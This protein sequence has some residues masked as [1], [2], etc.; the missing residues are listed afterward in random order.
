M[1]VLLFFAREVLAISRRHDVS[2]HQYI[3]LADSYPSVGK[4]INGFSNGSGVLIAPQWVL[5]ASHNLMFQTAPFAF[6]IGREVYHIDWAKRHFVALPWPYGAD[7]TL[8]IALAHLDR[9][10]S[11]VSP[12]PLYTGN[13]EL[14][15]LATIV[16]YGIPGDGWRGAPTGGS[17][18]HKRAAQNIIDAIG[19]YDGRQVD[20]DAAGT[21]MFYDFDNPANVKEAQN[22][23]GGSNIPLALEGMMTAGDSGGGVFVDTPQ[24]RQLIGISSGVFPGHTAGSSHTYGIISRTVRVSSYIDWIHRTIARFESGV[25]PL[26]GLVAHW[27]FDDLSK[28]FAQDVSGVGHRGDLIR[29]IPAEGMI[30]GAIAFRAPPEKFN[31]PMTKQEYVEVP[32]ATSAWNGVIANDLKIEKDITVAVWIYRIMS[33]SATGSETSD[34]DTLVAKVPISGTDCDFALILWED[35]LRFYSSNNSYATSPTHDI[36]YETWIHIATTRAGSTVKFYVNGHLIGE[37]E[38]SGDF[39]VSD[40]PLIIGNFPD[41]GFNFSGRMDDLRIYNRSL[42]QEEVMLLADVDTYNNQRI[43]HPPSSG[44]ASR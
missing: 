9:P 7:L 18:A 41:T 33:G 43:H 27:D 24:G 14:G 17:Q 20:I 28:G 22:W 3:Q 11:H 44:N 1:L 4:F 15:M 36:P 16:G 19:H 12:V 34:I 37:N 40:N 21:L 31:D 30:G 13:D 35:H 2:D 29:A 5:I 42:N 8:D 6:E 10:V 23:F 32:N 39:N 26:K 25:E 38:L